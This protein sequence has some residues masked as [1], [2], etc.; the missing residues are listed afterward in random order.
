L[1]GFPI[2]EIA[3]L[4]TAAESDLVI[5]AGRFA[6]ASGGAG[7]TAGRLMHSHRV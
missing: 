2:A 3:L 6:V 1:A 4:A 7:P 5:N